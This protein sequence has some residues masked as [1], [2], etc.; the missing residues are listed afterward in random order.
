VQY[1]QTIR[2]EVKTVL[3]D[4]Q[5][6]G[7]ETRKQLLGRFGSVENVRHASLEDLRSVEGSAKRLPRRLNL[8]S[9]SSRERMEGLNRLFIALSICEWNDE[10]W[11]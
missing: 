10:F 7:P 8:G 11:V 2:D 6:V 1:H 5:G 3:D 9:N 4:V